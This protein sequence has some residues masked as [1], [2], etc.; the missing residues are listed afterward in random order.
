MLLPGTGISPYR[1]GKEI[2]RQKKCHKSIG[3]CPVGKINAG[4]HSLVH[5]VYL[6][7]IACF[8]GK[9]GFQELT[10]NSWRPDG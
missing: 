8:G 3:K 2:Y 1:M 10:A 9:T 7:R 5:G 4:N 6:S